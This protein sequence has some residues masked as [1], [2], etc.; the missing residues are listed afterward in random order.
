M[1]DRNFQRYRV[2]PKLFVHAPPFLGRRSKETGKYLSKRLARI[3]PPFIG[4]KPWQHSVYYFWW[5]FLRRH[6]GYKDC[7][8]RGG[9]GRY[10]KLYADFGDVHA[11]E[12]KDFWKWW[13][14]KLANGWK[15]GEYLFAEPAAR[16][17]LV[18][19]R[20]LNTQT[21]DTL[22]VTIPLEVRTPQLV[23]N[24]RKLL[25][26]HKT[27]VTAA[28]NKS[29][30]LYPVAAS[31]RL[32][33]LHQT[34]AVWD[35]WNEHKHRRKKYEQAELAGIYVNRVVNGETVESLQRADLPY[36]DVQQEV[37]RRQ[38]QAFNRY[39]AAA[40]EYIENVGKGQFPLRSK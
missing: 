23:K 5:E 30:A 10:K 37:R 31:V 35:T 32:S 21:N 15:R 27:Q 13:A 1:H 36:N 12:T 19:D 38:T 7:C 24:L 22:Q 3:Q 17:M 2:G 9:A 11:Y 6:E 29:R 34:L 18:Q 20:V 28:R 39:L 25:E 14:E 16:R 26:E 40:T 4:A 8:A 33:S